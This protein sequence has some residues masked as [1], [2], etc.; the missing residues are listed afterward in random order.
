M[1]STPGKGKPVLPLL[2]EG[3]IVIMLKIPHAFA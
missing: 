1:L 2:L 3:N